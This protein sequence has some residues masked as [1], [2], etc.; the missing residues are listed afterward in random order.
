MIII[1][2]I[3]R[4]CNVFVGTVIMTLVCIVLAG[5]AWDRG[6][7]WLKTKLRG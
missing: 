3:G 7:T 4:C 1:E 6:K 2:T 5:F